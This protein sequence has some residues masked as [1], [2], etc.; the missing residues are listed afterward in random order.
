MKSPIRPSVI[1]S[2]EYPFSPVEAKIKLDQNESSEDFPAELKAMAMQRLAQVN[3]NRYPDLHSETLCKAIADYE[4]W[5]TNGVVVTT[6]SNVLIALLTQ[7]AGIGQQVI[8]A[9]PN[10]ALYSLDASLLDAHL[11]EVPL[12]PDFSMDK[13]AFIA[14]IR[15]AEAVGTG[16]V[17]LTQPHAPSGTLAPEEDIKAIVETARGWIVVIDEAY[18]QFSGKDYKA[19]ANIHPHVVL[20][21]TFSKAWGL[22]GLRFGYALTSDQ[23]ARQLRKLVPPFTTSSLQTVA[24]QVALANPDYVSERVASIVLERERVFTA[25]L[26]HPV[27]QVYPSC[28]NFLLIRT[29]DAAQAF[30]QLLEHGVLVRRQDSYYGLEG[31]IRITIGTPD[32]NNAFLAA[33]GLKGL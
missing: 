27:W 29:P 22:A 33:A 30:N 10:F 18:C 21:R 2:P 16:I 19:L 26:N 23:V 3:W 7:L 11:T 12:R 1:A 20:L 8:T 14:A 6:G 17:Y 28:A 9:K 25:L 24:A 15:N 32:E 13:D 5:S 4:G 31:C